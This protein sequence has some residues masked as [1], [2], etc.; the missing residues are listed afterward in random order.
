MCSPRPFYDFPV[1]EPRRL[2]HDYFMAGR[3]RDGTVSMAAVQP[4]HRIF[5]R[6]VAKGRAPEEVVGELYPHDDVAVA[7]RRVQTPNVLALLGSLVSARW[8]KMVLL[9]RLSAIV[10]D[11]RTKQSER[12]TALRLGAQVSGHLNNPTDDKPSRRQTKV[13]LDPELEVKL[14][15]LRKAAGEP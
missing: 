7:L 14:A 4:K 3:K 15:R 1:D 8:E 6:E 5:A 10:A 12:I 2:H 13:K 11:E 9:S